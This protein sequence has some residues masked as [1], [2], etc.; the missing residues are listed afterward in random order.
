[1]PLSVQN[2]C[3]HEYFLKSYLPYRYQTL[4][5]G[6]MG[7]GLLVILSSLTLTKPDLVSRSQRSK[8]NDHENGSKWGNWQNVIIFLVII[9][10]KDTKPPFLGSHAFMKVISMYW[11]SSVRLRGQSM[12]PSASQSANNSNRDFSQRGFDL[13]FPHLLWWLHVAR[14]IIVYQTLWPWPWPKA[15]VTLKKCPKIEKWNF[16]GDDKTYEHQTRFSFSL[17]VEPFHYI[18]FD[19]VRSSSRSKSPWKGS[20]TWKF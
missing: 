16:L 14:V 3:L 7:K 11:P 5:G 17:L 2:L 9:H 4:H 13:Q 20:K 19:F 12:S 15:V 1:M 18:W 10:P 8:V 6:S